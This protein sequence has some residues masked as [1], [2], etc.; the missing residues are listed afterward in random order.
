MS[1]VCGDCR[2]FPEAGAVSFGDELWA[3]FGRLTG[4]QGSLNSRP[5]W[6]GKLVI[7][8]NS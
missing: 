4:W 2:I 1:I 5:K 8:L 6:W 7:E 3:E